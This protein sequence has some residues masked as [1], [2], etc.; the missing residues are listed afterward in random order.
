VLN[1]FDGETIRFF[2]LRTHYRS[3]FNHSDAGLDDARTGL[4]RL[5]T[6]LGSVAEVEALAIDWAEPQ[7]A[8]FKAAMDEDFNTPMALSVLFD[9][10]AELNRTGSLDVARQLK[11]L[12]GLLGL[13]QQSPQSYLQG[14]LSV[15]GLDAAAIEAKIQARADAKKAR[16]FAGADR[17]RAELAALGIE[18]KDSPQGTTW[19]KA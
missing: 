16:D 14:G 4:R 13:L 5:Y 18:L 8:R 17:I 7:A 6:A 11:S 1:H 9:L 10:A 3:P 12:G 15:G 2:M 19:V